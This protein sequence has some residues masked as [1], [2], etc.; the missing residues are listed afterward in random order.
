MLNC[1]IKGDLGYKYNNFNKIVLTKSRFLVFV[2]A[3]DLQSNFVNWLSEQRS[4]ILLI[5]YF[6]V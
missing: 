6:F 3:L 4:Q 5:L 1:S 2:I